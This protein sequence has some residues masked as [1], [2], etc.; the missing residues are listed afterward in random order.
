MFRQREQSLQE[1]VL[2]KWEAGETKK[3]SKNSIER[4]SGILALVSKSR[5]S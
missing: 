2:V 4:D 1:A 5:R 3:R